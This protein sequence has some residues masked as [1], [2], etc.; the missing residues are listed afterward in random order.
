M[1]SPTH[2][3]DSL[4]RYRDC[5]AAVDCLCAAIVHLDFFTQLDHSP[6]NLAAICRQFGITP[7][8]TDVMLSLFLANGF[9]FRDEQGLLHTTDQAREFLVQGSAF[10][11][12]PYYASLAD[13]PG[14]TDFLKVL[15]TDK[16]ANWPGAKS[17]ADWHAAMRT[18]SF[19]ES[20]TAAMDCRGR[21]LAPALATAIDLRDVRTLLDVGGGS[22]VYAIACAEAHPH[23]QT[24]VLESVPVDA[25][26]RRTIQQANL[27]DRISVVAGDMFTTAWPTDCDAHLFS[28]VLHDWD[29]SDCRRL[30]AASAKSLAPQG[31]LLIHDMLLNDEK[32]GPLWAAEYSVLLASVTQGRL[33]CAAEIS[34]WLQGLGFSILQHTP[35]A[36]GRSVLQASRSA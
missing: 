29:E 22:G 11:A 14:V 33:Y 23:L 9:I 10:D 6:G 18:E 24:I 26:A 12:R 4:Y 2:N 32:T 15:R 31:R 7:R 27:S 5:L 28:N 21:V 25:I 20:F 17:E 36:L 34:E 3:A 16:P 13:R 19:A 8:P 30:L 35:T 1:R